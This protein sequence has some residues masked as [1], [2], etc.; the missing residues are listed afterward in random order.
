MLAS[1]T[2]ALPSMSDQKC[3]PQNSSSV[4]AFCTALSQKEKSGNV[5]G[6][7][8][9]LSRSCMKLESLHAATIILRKGSSSNTFSTAQ[10]GHPL[11]CTQSCSSD[12]KHCSQ[13][14]AERAW[15]RNATS[16][17]T[18]GRLVLVEVVL[19]QVERRLEAY[20]AACACVWR[21][22]SRTA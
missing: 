17:S 21:M 19:E 6:V 16:R 4:T 13:E 11:V 12:M 18:G 10:A 20:R 3:R 7:P 2:I 8:C 1:S 22:G 5:L 9:T 14:K 15:P